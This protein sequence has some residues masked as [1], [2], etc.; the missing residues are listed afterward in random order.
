[1]SS[2]RKT[3]RA[4]QRIVPY[5]RKP[6]GDLSQRQKR[7]REHVFAIL[8]QTIDNKTLENPSSPG[9]VIEDSSTEIPG[10][11]AIELHTHH[12][13]PPHSCQLDLNSVDA[14]PITVDLPSNAVETTTRTSSSDE[15]VSSSED[16]EAD[17]CREKNVRPT[18]YTSRE[19]LRSFMIDSSLP[20]EHCNNLIKILKEAPPD[21]FLTLPDCS[22][23]LLET[24]RDPLSIRIVEPG[25]YIHIGIAVGLT[26]WLDSVDPK[27]IPQD[28]LEADYS[29]DGGKEKGKSQ[30]WPI[31][32][33][34]VNIPKSKPFVVG[35]YK[36]KKKP[37]NFKSFFHDF[38]T[39]YRAIRQAGG[40]TYKGKKIPFKL[41]ALIADG[42][43]RASCLNCKGLNS[44]SPCIRCTITG[45]KS[46][47]SKLEKRAPESK[48]QSVT[49]GRVAKKKIVKKL[50]RNLLPATTTATKRTDK[51]FR[52][53]RYIGELQ[54]KNGESACLDIIDMATEVPFEYMHLVC[55]GV[56]GR[57]LSVKVDG[58]HKGSAQFYQ[59]D[60][61]VLRRRISLLKEYCPDDFS[62]KPGFL[63]DYENF[64]ATEFRQQLLHTGVALYHDLLDP[65][66]F[67]YFLLL[68]VSIRILTRKSSTTED[69]AI[70]K[71]MLELFVENS[72]KQYGKTFMC[73]NV[74]CLCHL[75]EDVLN[76]GLLDEFSAFPYENNM[77]L[78]SKLCRKQHQTLQQISHRL[79]EIASCEKY[80]KKENFPRLTIRHY[81]GSGPLDGT[82]PYQEQYKVLLTEEFRFTIDS[83]SKANSCII[84]N[85]NSVC[86]IENLVS[87]QQA[88]RLIVKKYEIVEDFYKMGS[89]SSDVGIYKCSSLGRQSFTIELHEIKTKGYKMPLFKGSDVVSGNFV[90]SELSQSI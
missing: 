11:S 3:K 17:N 6:V 66:E 32:V 73:S 84:L 51:E 62:R 38:N 80:K 20:E 65:R 39:E 63:E 15:L 35:V 9:D 8:S 46:K 69:F 53:G 27:K 61:A 26:R 2:A 77:G 54:L 16:D 70:A 25:E 49:R 24:P 88:I 31:Q 67:Q 47:V 5:S 78:V 83:Y 59:E 12:S 56:F 18:A 75:V 19:R 10:P 29:T 50:N 82:S 89:K 34:A 71:G 57:W 45:K 33:R 21:A 4:L 58:L 86:Q 87:D 68:H 42:P 23:T 72:K 41:R 13:S 81:S 76:F 36:G 64:K 1:M 28:L 85:D 44:K 52:D 14:T 79:S 60:L 55:I 30:S 90:V 22:K 7:H 43:A 74:H 48:L 37:G 40:I